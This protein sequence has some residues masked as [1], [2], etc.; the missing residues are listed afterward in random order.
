MFCLDCAVANC[1]DGMPT[2]VLNFLLLCKCIMD[3]ERV[4]YIHCVHYN[5]ASNVVGIMSTGMC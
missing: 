1:S 2:C 4:E 3:F 5:L